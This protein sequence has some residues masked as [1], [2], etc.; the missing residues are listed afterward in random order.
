LKAKGVAYKVGQFPFKANSR[1]KTA[2]ETEGFVKMLCENRSGQILGV[3][4]LGAHASEL[5]HKAV[6]AM[7]MKASAHEIALSCHAHPTL[8]KV[9][10]E[11]AL[12]IVDRPIHV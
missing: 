3:H 4:I 2:D 9:I 7:R 12:A 6:L 8:S 10:R 11:A 5:I 1:A